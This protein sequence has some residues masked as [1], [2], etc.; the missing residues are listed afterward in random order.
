VFEERREQE[1][2]IRKEQQQQAKEGRI[3]ER[4]KHKE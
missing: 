2:G 3:E 4:W 1:T